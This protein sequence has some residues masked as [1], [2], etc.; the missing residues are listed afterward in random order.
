MCREQCRGKSDLHLK[1][2]GHEIV[3]EHGRQQPAACLHVVAGETR[4]NGINVHGEQHVF[5]VRYCEGGT[6]VM[7][8]QLTRIDPERKAREQS[9]CEDHNS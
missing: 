1:I 7:I 4:H 6:L 9:Q 2:L 5:Y 3:Q 8:S